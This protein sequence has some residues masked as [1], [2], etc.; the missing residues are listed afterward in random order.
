MRVGGAGKVR[1]WGGRK[2]MRVGREGRYESGE[3]G[4]DE[5]VV[6][7]GEGRYERGGGGKV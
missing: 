7:G 3:G 5:S 6:G 2:D 4:K 1:E